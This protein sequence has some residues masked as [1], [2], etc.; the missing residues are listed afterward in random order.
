MFELPLFPERASTIAGQVDNL[1]FFLLGITGFFAILVAVLIF[2]F[3]IRYRRGVRAK[4][5]QIEGSIPL[6]LAWTF[7]PFLFFLVFFFWGAQI[8]LTERQPPKNAIQVDVVGKQW[9][10]KIQHMEG[11]REIDEL[12]IPVHRP[13]QLRMISQDVIHDFFVPAFRTKF[14][15]L[16]N[17]YTM[18]WFEATK[19]GRYHLFCAQYC[20]TQHSHMIGWVVVMEPAEYQAWLTASRAEGSMAQRGQK[21]LQDFGCITCHRPDASGRGPNLVGL[22]G[23][24][25]YLEDSRTVTADAAYIRESILDPGAK[26]VAGFR[27]LMPT[28]RTQLSEEDILDIIEYIRSIGTDEQSQP[29][30]N[31][32]TT[33]PGPRPGETR[34]ELLTK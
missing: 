25:V 12:H 15:V 9:M 7:I 8:Y 20:G 30:N 31:R 13:V 16:P 29:L 18:E 1:L 33:P 10:W 24:Q 27:N 2:Y 6:E 17:R 14:D 23:K 19:T 32:T 3:G 26:I 34:N 22:W 4:A 21:L 28:F 5:E 11:P